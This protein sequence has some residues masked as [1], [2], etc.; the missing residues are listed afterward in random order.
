[1]KKSLLVPAALILSATPALAMGPPIKEGEVRVIERY[2]AAFG[3]LPEG[4]AVSR[5]GDIYVTLAGSGELREIDRKTKVGTTL[6]NFDVGFGFLLGMA[7]DDDE[8]YVVL[9]SFVDETSGVWHVDDMGNTERVVAFPGSAF[10]ND[11]TFDTE[12][13]L[14]ITESIG[15]AVY[16]VE[17]DELDDY[18]G[19]P[20]T[21]TLWVQDDL[22]VGDVEVSPVPFPIGANGIAYDD[23]NALVLV[24]NSQD[25]RIVE[26]EDN[27]GQAGMLAVVAE[28]EYLR[29]ADGIALGKSGDLYV[30][31]NFSSTV[32]RLDPW[33]ASYEI[34]ADGSD[35][36]VFPSTLAFGQ[37][38]P[39]KRSVFI[40]N[41]GFGAGPQ[42]PVGLI[43]L[44]VGE[45]GEK[46]PAGK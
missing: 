1:M 21:P 3:E 32:L 30:V 34:L 42:A 23:E 8:L 10:P 26:I 9:A 37:W 41:F 31:A 25:P 24:A 27:G 4:V 16:R 46:H 14:F 15:G 35:G 11:L 44:G 39:D 45:K 2:D 33:D 17:A 38:G 13:N 43:Q 22:L 5:N 12:G 6:A 18:A 36:L 29:G 20:I 7:F 28:G 19:I 40:A